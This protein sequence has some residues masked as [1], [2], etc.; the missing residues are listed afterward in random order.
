MPITSSARKAVRQS[1]RKKAINSR[2]KKKFTLSIKSFEK[3][4]KTG[5]LPTVYKIIDLATKKNLIH[6]NKA[7][8]IKS[9]LS[10]LASAKITKPKTPVK[11]KKT[12]SKIQKRGKMTTKKA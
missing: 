4:P 1:R 11:P 3:S 8:R 2:T 5:E 6:A 12:T 7:S 9:R 10:K